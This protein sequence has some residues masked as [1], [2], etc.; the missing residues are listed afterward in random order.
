MK[1]FKWLQVFVAIALIS[2]IYPCY[3]QQ[4][5]TNHHIVKTNGL[6]VQLSVSGEIENIWLGQK[7]ISRPVKAITQIAGCRQEG[8]VKSQTFPD[9]SIEFSRV[10]INDSLHTS[11][12]LTDRFIPKDNSI[13]WEI[14]IS[15]KDQS[16]G[17]KI[18]TQL[19]YSVTKN[20][21]FWT[22]WAGA[23]HD[24]TKEELDARAFK[25]I[26]PASSSSE[27][28]TKNYDDWSDALL[29]L[30]F[31]NATLYYGAPY[32]DYEKPLLGFWPRRGDIFSIPVYSILEGPQNS[33]L[34]V[35]LSPE[36]NIIDLILQTSSD[37]T[38]SFSRL[39][40]RISKDN[41]LT[42]ALDLI[43][44]ENDWRGSLD[45]MSKRYPQYFNPKIF[46]AKKFSGTGAYSNYFSDFDTAKMK[47]MAFTVNW[48]A[49]FDFPYM[50]M[51]IPP[52]KKGESW[53]RFGGDSISVKKMDDYARKMKDDGFYV[54]S[55]FNVTEFG[56]YIKYPLKVPQVK[57]AADDWKSS[58]D[59]LYNRLSSAILTVPAKMNYRKNVAGEKIFG[60]WVGSIAMDCGDPVYQDFL[61][62]QA[63]RHITE[64]PNSFGICID[65]MDWLR[66]FNENA[67]D[68]ISWFDG[69]P[70]RSLVT[71]WKQIMSKLGPMMHES[72][73][74][75]LVNNHTKRIDLL[76]ETDG[77]FDEFTYAGTSLNATAFLALNKPAMGWTDTVATIRSEGGD[78]FFQKY[79]YMGILPMCPFPGN[80][81]SISPDP[82]TDQL[83]LD[84]GPLML[85]MKE[86]SWVLKP[87]AVSVKDNAAKV[88]MFNV[89]QGYAIPVMYAVHGIQAAKVTFQNTS[90]K[91]IVSCEVYHPG[92]EQP[93]LV[94]FKQKGS[95]VILDVPVERGCGMLVVKTR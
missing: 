38:A 83:Y 64:I 58:N 6:I 74:A 52:V 95:S 19:K 5:V 40:N 26:Y 88:N 54:F 10:L 41:V 16:W 21:R 3:G 30:P 57:N 37:G 46:D 77:F 7:K 87:H 86:R 61:L 24:K 93:V 89:P 1:A 18:T 29:P 22:T 45:W 51:F 39:H 4:S 72:G 78:N 53:K 13:R 35:A 15:G 94:K 79:L 91:E 43:P 31:T 9:G 63:R 62:Q 81:H 48:Q 73:K 84:Y 85:A 75:I 23:Q 25:E 82:F 67:D 14:G 68:G 34:T 20:T 17:S 66:L 59:F 2:V 27:N 60:S 56:D 8:D 55:Y 76:N 71:S 80:D 32:M 11:C 47:K 50:G 44:G 33:G 28:R 70:V 65:R 69:R 42:F 92:K 36:D 49:S 90:G 12:T